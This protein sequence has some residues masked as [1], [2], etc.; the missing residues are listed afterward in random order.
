MS[1]LDGLT[2]EQ[3]ANLEEAAAGLAATNNKTPEETIRILRE[4]V[5]KVPEQ[6]RE[7]QEF[8]GWAY[9]YLAGE[10]RRRRREARKIAAAWVG[11][12]VCC[13]ILW[14]AVTILIARVF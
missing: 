8:Q 14:L 12:V 11:L 13:L 4:Q 7:I 6:L 9:T 5:A 10:E 3:R 1:A 2:P